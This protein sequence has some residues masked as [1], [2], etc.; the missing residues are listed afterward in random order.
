M[1][2]SNSLNN[3]RMDKKSF[4]IAALEDDSDEKVYWLSKKPLERIY[5]V[6]LMRQMFYGYDH[7]TARLQR[8][9][10]IDELL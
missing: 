9:F 4:S 3:I 1:G 7:S 2:R 8:I 6:E 10:E 5:A